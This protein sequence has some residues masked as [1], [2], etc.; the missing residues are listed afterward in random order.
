[1]IQ[2]MLGGL[3]TLGWAIVLFILFV[4]VV[5]LIFRESL[6]GHEEVGEDAIAW[7]FQTVPRSMFTIFR[8]SFGD[9]S[10][11]NGTPLFEHMMD[12]ND[13]FWSFLFSVFIFFMVI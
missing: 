6:G 7:Y 4:Y 10:T 1:M 2:G 12:D 8:C 5:S 13:V 3:A 9:C 11:K